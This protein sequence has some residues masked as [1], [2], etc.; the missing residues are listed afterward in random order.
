MKRQITQIPLRNQACFL[1]FGLANWLRIRRC[2]RRTVLIRRLYSIGSRCKLFM[3]LLTGLCLLASVFSGCALSAHPTAPWPSDTSAPLIPLALGVNI[4]FTEPKAGELEMIAGAGFRWVRTDF[5]WQATEAAKGTYDFSGYDRL[6]SALERNHL[7]A[8]FILDY[9]NKL[10]DS[11]HAPYTAE[12]REAFA[13]WAAAAVKHFR[14][15][16]IT[17]EIYNEPNTGF[18]TPAPNA[19]DYIKLAIEASKAI[20]QTAPE[21]RIIGPAVWGFD[22]PFIE[23]CLRA[24]LLNYWSAISVHPYRKSDPESVVE[25][26]ARLRNLIQQYAPA[27]K[28]VPIISSEWGYSSASFNVGE[29]KQDSLLARQML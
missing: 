19:S 21:E 4:H 23:Q 16:G 28:R 24:G 3:R 9:T 12:G 2:I 7:R 20:H 27:N 22:F 18:W 13:K 25:D 6:L 29:E 8:L 14:G 10:Y 15:R 17:W 1:G 11:D 26:Y 5:V